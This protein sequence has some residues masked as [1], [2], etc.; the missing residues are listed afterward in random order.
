LRHG[1]AWQGGPDA[2]VVATVV[3]SSPT[4]VVD[5]GSDDV[6]RGVGITVVETGSD[7]VGSGVASVFVVDRE[8]VVVVERAVAVVVSPIDTSQNCPRKPT[9]HAHCR[10]R[11]TVRVAVDVDVVVVVVVVVTNVAVVVVVAVE[12]TVAA[13]VAAV[14][15]TL[16]VVNPALVVVKVVGATYVTTSA[17]FETKE[18]FWLASATTNGDPRMSSATATASPLGRSV[19]SNAADTTIVS[20][21]RRCRSPPPPDSMPTAKRASVA[22][23]GSSK[24]SS[25]S[26]TA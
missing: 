19:W 17:K 4:V 3:S 20:P 7:D 25:A 10:P 16:T 14:S 8:A 12:G 24:R 6:G 11:T 9:G 15:P 2:L 21:S 18:S 1:N 5:V 13:D 22:A 26:C 23:A